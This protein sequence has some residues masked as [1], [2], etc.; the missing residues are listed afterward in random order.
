MSKFETIV[1]FNPN[2][3]HVEDM[4]G[5]LKYLIERYGKVT[6]VEDWGIR[7]LAYPI[8]KH[9]QGHY[10]LMNYETDKPTECTDTIQK[11]YETE[12]EIIKHIIVKTD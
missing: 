11:Y 9:S 2:S 4:K 1:I 3:K 5:D 12:E 7:K 10:V 8:K 6:N